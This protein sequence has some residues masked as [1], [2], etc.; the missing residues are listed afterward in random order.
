MLAAWVGPARAGDGGDQGDD[1]PGRR[2]GDE[3]AADGGGR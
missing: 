3:G 1:N 2:F